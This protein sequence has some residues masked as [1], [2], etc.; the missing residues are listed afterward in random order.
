MSLT[1][2]FDNSMR[3][4]FGTTIQ[5]TESGVTRLVHAARSKT[6]SIRSIMSFEEQVPTGPE[7]VLLKE[8]GREEPNEIEARLLQLLEE[9]PVWTRPAMMNQLTPT[10]VKMIH[11]CV[12][13]LA[14][15]KAWLTDRSVAL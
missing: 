12:C 3:P 5:T 6:R 15:Q 8:L 10:E 14:F 11:A 1:R 9:R 4:A 7:E 2:A 13:L